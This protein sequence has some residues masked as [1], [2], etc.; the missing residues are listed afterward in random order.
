MILERRGPSRRGED[1]AP[2]GSNMEEGGSRFKAEA[3]NERGARDGVPLV[4]QPKPFPNHGPMFVIGNHRGTTFR[5]V[6][7][8]D[9]GIVQDRR[10]TRTSRV[11]DVCGR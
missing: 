1:S 5:A 11:P 8:L 7:E 3:R 4:V 9:A 6:Y 2:S 10:G